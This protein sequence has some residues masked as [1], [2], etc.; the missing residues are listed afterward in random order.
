MAKEKRTNRTRY[1]KEQRATIIAT[2]DRDGLTAK[3]VQKKFGVVP[4]TYYAWRKRAAQAQRGTPARAGGSSRD[5]R[6][7][8]RASLARQLPKIVDE[9]VNRF[10]REMFGRG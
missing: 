3:D 4:V 6:M 7:R 5:L 9:E 10:L 1:T 8:V 2:A